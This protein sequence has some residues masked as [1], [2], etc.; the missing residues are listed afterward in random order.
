[1]TDIF[2]VP[3]ALM[4]AN[5]ELRSRRK[6]WQT[7]ALSLVACALFL[8]QKSITLQAP[9]SQ[10]GHSLSVVLLCTTH[11]TLRLLYFVFFLIGWVGSATESCWQTTLQIV[12]SVCH[13]ISIYSCAC[14]YIY[15]CIYICIYIYIYVCVYCKNST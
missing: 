1:M 14:V 7:P 8:G 9:C 4:F 13:L 10:Q 6:R 11:L 3:A 2:F 12:L 15:L 5:L